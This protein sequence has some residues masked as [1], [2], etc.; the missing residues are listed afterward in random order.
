MPPPFAA[1]VTV[2]KNKQNNGPALP[3]N[4]IEKAFTLQELESAIKNS[5]ST[6]PGFDHFTYKIIQNLPHSA[7]LY[8]LN[9]FNDWWLKNNYVDQ[10]KEII[11]CVILKPYKDQNLPSSYRPISLMSCLMKTFERMIKTRLEWYI[12]NK[13]LLPETQYGFRRGQG[14]IDAITQLVTDVQCTFSNNSFLACFFLDLKGAYDSVDLNFLEVKLNN[15]G[16]KA[17][18]TIT[19]IFR[20]RKIHI[21]DHNNTLHGSRIVSQGLPQGSVLSPLLFNIYTADLHRMFDDSIKCIQYA[22]DICIYTIH[23]SYNACVN[24]IKHI[25]Y[26]VK[27][28]LIDHGFTMSPEKSAVMVFTRHRL[29]TLNNINLSGYHIPIVTQYKYLGMILDNKLIWTKHI[30]YVKDKCE[31]GINMLKCVSKKKWGADAMISLTFY[32]S[33]IRSVMD[34]GSVLYGSASNSN[35]LVLDR[36]QYKSLRIC[37]GAMKS[38]P[39]SA[40]LAEAQEPPLALR[41]QLLASKMLI[42]IRSYNTNNILNNIYFLNIENLSNSYWRLK[43]SPPLVDAFTETQKFD[44]LIQ[45]HSIYP[46][47]KLNFDELM[48]KPSVVFPGYSDIPTVNKCLMKSILA[49]YNKKVEIYTDGSKMDGRTSCA[50]YVSN[51]K[52]IH[53]YRLHDSCSIFTAEAFAIECALM[54]MIENNIGDTIIISDSRSVLQAIDNSGL[55]NYKNTIICNIKILLN[56]LYKNRTTVTLIWTKGH[57]GIIG[58]EIVDQAAKEAINLTEVCT[59]SSNSDIVQTQKQ[60]TRKKWEKIWLEYVNSTKNPYSLIHPTLPKSIPHISKFPV[61]KS[62]SATITRLKLN[63]GC[64]PAHLCKIGIKDTP[65]C[66]CDNASIGDLN[67]IFFSCDNHS[68]II[69]EFEDRLKTLK[70]QFPINIVSLLSTENKDIYDAIVAFVRKA[71]ISI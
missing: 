51:T 43:N 11:I 5:P 24:D 7:K 62:Y 16:I 63:H 40:I 52:R 35:L 38:S 37:I 12:E 58:N 55:K 66:P 68:P 2:P 10:L 18:S 45:R 1:N 59:V 41:R 64:F 4:P 39:C 48:F 60:T 49:I 27:N 54:W 70:V 29:K 20:N 26:C 25:A 3:D 17:S 42:K 69:K 6:A 67:H 9:I 15:L 28:W 23:D 36:I 34:Y 19:E 32:R 8:L 33:Y 30:K 13:S 22:D 71:A 65:Y 46:I 56:S 31:K 50:F 61:T 57:Y 44:E 14:T 21:R 47:F 53:K